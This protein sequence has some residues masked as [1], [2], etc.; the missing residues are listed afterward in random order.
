M[1]TATTRIWTFASVIL[2]IIVIALGWFL[3]VAPKLA[4]ANRF[5]SERR[6]VEAQNE[7]ARITIAQFE[8]DLQR[9]DELRD[10]LREFRGEFPTGAEYDVVIEE[11][12]R[13]MLA[14]GLELQNLDINE[15]APASAVAPAEGEAPETEIDGTGELPTGSLLRVT[16]SITVGGSIE[17][18]LAYIDRLQLSSRFS[19]IAS[20]TYTQGTNT[21]L[22]A[23]RFTLVLYV[24]TGDELSEVET[25]EPT[26]TEPEP[27]ETPSPE[28]TDPAPES[29]EP[30]PT[31]TPTP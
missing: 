2:M 31:P 22:R 17:Q 14:E 10:E 27:T 7:L 23:M 9:I 28:V 16:A 21:E 3:G 13:G 1:T 20:G 6:N 24:V 30:E 26:E 15:P 19:V 25:A 12:L 11:F 29:T 18:V 4:E 5:D 8:S